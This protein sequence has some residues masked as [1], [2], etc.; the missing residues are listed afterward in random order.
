MAVF[1]ILAVLTAFWYF[2]AADPAEIRRRAED[3][4]SKG[5]YGHAIACYDEFLKSYGNS[6]EADE[7]RG[8]RVMAELRQASQQA[9]K[10]GDWA[11]AV[12]VA[13]AQVKAIPKSP[14]SDLLQKVGVALAQIGEGAARQ[15]QA[16][17]DL[18]SVNRLRNM[19]NLIETSI[20]AAARPADA[21]LAPINRVL[22]LSGQKVEG[23]NE[24]KN[25]V[26][27]I[28]KAVAADD[29]PRAYAAYRNVG[30]GVS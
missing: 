27:E 7:I 13:Q 1:A 14:S 10:S 4:S 2:S 29:L 19:M 24:I 11:A 18:A 8:L 5:D 15:T 23:R 28:G 22:K 9:D 16:Q 17:P 26:D 3:A 30:S 12:E 20:P 25:A 21:M 6:R